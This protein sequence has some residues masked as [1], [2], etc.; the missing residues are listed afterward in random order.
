M[1]YKGHRYGEEERRSRWLPAAATLCSTIG[2]ANLLRRAA[3]L[4]AYVL[5]FEYAALLA[6]CAARI[7]AQRGCG[8]FW[9]GL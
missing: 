9:D 4:V 3:L 5:V 2:W 7:S 8:R 6:P 1:T